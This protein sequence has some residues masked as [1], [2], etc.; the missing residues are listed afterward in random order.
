MI[1]AHSREC[2]TLAIPSV[3]EPIECEIKLVSEMPGIFFQ[4]SSTGKDAF[5]IPYNYYLHDQWHVRHS[6]EAITQIVFKI[7]YVRLPL[8]LF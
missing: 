4:K 5:Q 1:H 6:H 3:Y 8:F 2:L 7:C